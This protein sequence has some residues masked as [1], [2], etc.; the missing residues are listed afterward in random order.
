[1]ERIREYEIKSTLFS[2]HQAQQRQRRQQIPVQAQLPQTPQPQPPQSLI[3]PPA[4]PPVQQTPT[5]PKAFKID[6]RRFS[7]PQAPP[8]PAVQQPA[9]PQPSQLPAQQPPQPPAQE[10][11]KRNLGTAIGGDTDIPAQQQESEKTRRTVRQPPSWESSP[12]PWS[13]RQFQPLVQSPQ[14][15]QSSSSPRPPAQQPL[16]PT[17]ANQRAE[18]PSRFRIDR[19]TPEQRRQDAERQ[20]E[21]PPQP[22]SPGK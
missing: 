16:P 21:Q 3:Q 5:Q 10:R 15:P 1:M 6:R 11:L 20:A 13:A 7:S 4:Q 2:L 22:R 9:Q 14:P 19:R 18:Q 12:N 17:P 8:Q